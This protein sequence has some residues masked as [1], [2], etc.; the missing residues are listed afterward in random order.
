MSVEL[1]DF[2]SE[3]LSGCCG[4]A[5]ITPDKDGFGICGECGEWSEGED[6]LSEDNNDTEKRNTVPG[7]QVREE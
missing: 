1:R 2:Y 3:D 6:N 7:G 5:L 4:A